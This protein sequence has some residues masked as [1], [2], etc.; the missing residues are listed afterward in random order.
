M[1]DLIDRLTLC[2]VPETTA[3]CITNDFVRRNKLCALENYVLAV[4]A[5]NGKR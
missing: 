1:C 4:E 3:L 5:E 2:G